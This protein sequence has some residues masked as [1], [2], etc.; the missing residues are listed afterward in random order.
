MGVFMKGYWLVTLFSLLILAG[1]TH[2]PIPVAASYPATAQRKM[3]AA[4]HWDVLA[5]D[6]AQRI[7]KTLELTFP[8][9]TV[10]PSLVVK[11][12]KA[13]QDIPFGKAFSTLL[14]TK[15]VQQGSV[16][17]TDAAQYDNNTLSVEYDMQVVHHKDR[18]LTY[19]PPGLMTALAAG[20]WMIAQAQDRWKYPG[21]AMFPLAIAADVNS[22]VEYYLPGET[23]T[24]VILS[25]S[26][27]MGKQY[28]FGD[29]RI[30][31]INDGDYDH[32]ENESK[33]YRM[34]N[35]W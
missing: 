1:C 11:P 33:M 8:N 30:Y 3:Q 16:V 22:A 20:V 12:K 31:Y 14:R 6:V 27:A 15:L 19:L 4:Y 5:N 2:R 7:K 26:I 13:Q 35:Q 21:L 29:S 34:V 25:T 24:E 32:Y 10:K 17:M 28:I 9:A 23:N 18:R